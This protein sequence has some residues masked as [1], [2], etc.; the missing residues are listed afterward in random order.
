MKKVKCKKKFGKWYYRIEKAQKYASFRIDFDTYFLYNKE[1]ELE[2]V[3]ETYK[4]MKEYIKDN[5]IILKKI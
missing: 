1:L 5:T 2:N 3:F 4:E